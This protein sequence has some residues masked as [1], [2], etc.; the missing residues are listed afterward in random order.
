MLLLVSYVVFILFSVVKVL[1]LLFHLTD[2][3][4]FE[5]REDV[6]FEC[7]DIELQASGWWGGPSNSV[8]SADVCSMLSWCRRCCSDCGR[9][10][11]CT[12]PSAA[13]LSERPTQ[14]GHSRTACIQRSVWIRLHFVSR[15]R[16][17][18]GDRNQGGMFTFVCCVVLVYWF[19][20]HCMFFHI[21]VLFSFFSVGLQIGYEDQQP[22]M[23]NTKKLSHICCVLWHSAWKR[24]EL[25]LQLQS[26]RDV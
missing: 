13:F 15:P 16:V 11:R 26:S 4:L 7:L 17:I 23:L 19:V 2:N 20:P 25:I 22:R 9:K 8:C 24:G 6:M 1:L 5:G 3:Q 10:A 12:E 18:R 14:L 21:S